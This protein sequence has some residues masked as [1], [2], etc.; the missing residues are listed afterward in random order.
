M[1]PQTKRLLAIVVTLILIFA[2]C[3]NL[4]AQERGKPAQA[5][6]VYVLKQSS[7]DIHISEFEKH[8]I[9]LQKEFEATQIILAELKQLRTQLDTL[10][11][12]KQKAK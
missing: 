2:V 4:T 3:H 11:V 12:N 6:T 5:D 7:L 1:K 10:I 8:L 9:N